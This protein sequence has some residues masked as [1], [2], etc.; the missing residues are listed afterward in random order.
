M[1]IGRR[2]T[3]IRNINNELLIIPNGVL[4]NA[5]VMNFKL[6][7]LSVRVVIPFSA[8]IG[9]DHIKIKNMVLEILKKTGRKNVIM[10]DKDKEP[11][12][13]L[14]ELGT[15]NIKFEAVFWVDNFDDKGSTK[16][17]IICDIYSVLKK[18]KIQFK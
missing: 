8:K 11:K 16:E 1:D 6:P 14:A 5:T 13:N 12:V 4:G 10:D 15:E 9:S 18:N 7:D 3:R 2:S 17:R